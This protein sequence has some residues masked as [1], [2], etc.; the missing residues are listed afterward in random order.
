MAG[1]D[2]YD[3]LR[4]FIDDGE[5]CSAIKKTQHGYQFEFLIELHIDDLAVLNF[6]QN[7][8]NIGKVYVYSSS[9]SL[10]RKVN[11]QA[12]IKVLIAILS[13]NPLNTAKRLDF[14]DWKY[15]F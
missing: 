12:D 1:S 13:H 2:L 15:A 11:R 7:K 6:L 3:W 4:G 8:L 9:A 5:G 14:E 10:R